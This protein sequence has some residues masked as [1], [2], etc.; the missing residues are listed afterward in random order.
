MKL[1]ERRTELRERREA[2]LR[3]REPS[4]SEEPVPDVPDEQNLEDMDLDV[5]GWEEK[6][7][8]IFYLDLT[9]GMA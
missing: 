4:F 1:E 6:G 3:Q 9:T 8:Y 2:A 7:R 5:P